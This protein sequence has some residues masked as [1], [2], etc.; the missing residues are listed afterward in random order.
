MNRHETAIPAIVLALALSGCAQP[1]TLVQPGAAPGAPAVTAPTLSPTGP[2]STAKMPA[3]N[4]P[5]N[6][7]EWT[8]GAVVTPGKVTF[9]AEGRKAGIFISKGQFKGSTGCTDFLGKVTLA[10]PDQ[11]V[12][13][14]LR[15]GT[16]SCS[17]AA[18]ATQNQ[19]VL[20]I[21]KDASTYLV[22]GSVLTLTAEADASA[23][24]FARA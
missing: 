21:L 3:G 15:A 9:A 24:T 12:S 11:W 18:L 16:E 22:Q 1:A 20:T 14:S 17:S 8:L 23:L 6:D 10:E 4:S 7:S 13:G 2:V 19:S 5:L